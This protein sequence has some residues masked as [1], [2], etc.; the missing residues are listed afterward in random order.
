[1][2]TKGYKQLC[3]EAEAE[4]E[5]LTVAQ[6]V[7][8]IEDPEVEIIDIRDIRELWREGTVP[9]SVHAPRGML[10]FWVDPES[11]YYRELFGSGKKFVFFCAGGLRSALATQQLQGMGLEPVAH[12]EGGFDAWKEAGAPMVEKER[13]PPK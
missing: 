7:E 12:I 3:A 6:A 13:K 4:I 5:T 8:L 10:E 1:M 2:I 9:G 11:P